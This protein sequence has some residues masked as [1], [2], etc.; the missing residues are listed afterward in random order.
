MA[1]LLGRLAFFVFWHGILPYKENKFMINLLERIGIV[2][3][4]S[5]KSFRP[6]PA[7]IMLV[8]MLTFVGTTLYILISGLD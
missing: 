3:N 6:V 4:E 1:L 2:Q 5:N 7:I 8:L